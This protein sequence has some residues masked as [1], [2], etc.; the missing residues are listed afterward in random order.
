M[1]RHITRYTDR[2]LRTDSH[3]CKITRDRK[4]RTF[5]FAKGYKDEHKAHILE[6]LSFKW[7]ATW[8]EAESRATGM[9]Q[10]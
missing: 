5:T 7:V 1:K 2:T 9:M 3:W 10:F 6:T 4:N 8:E